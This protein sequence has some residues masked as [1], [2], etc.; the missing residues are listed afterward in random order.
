MLNLKKF[1]CGTLI[2]AATTMT[3]QAKLVLD[4]FEYQAPTDATLT[5]FVAGTTVRFDDDGE[6][7]P[8]PDTY[9]D[10]AGPITTT[11]AFGG[12]DPVSGVSGTVVGLS[13]GGGVTV[14]DFNVIGDSNNTNNEADPLLRTGDGELYV[15]AGPAYTLTISYT[16]PLGTNLQ[17][18]ASQGSAFYFDIKSADFSGANNFSVVI[19]V[20]DADGNSDTATVLVPPTNITSL[21]TLTLDFDKF[22]GVDFTRVQGIVAYIT[23]EGP[24]LDLRIS[25]VGIVPEPASIALLGLGLLCLGLRSRKK[26]A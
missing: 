15:A 6:L 21:T 8:Y 9:G 13:A 3:A 7:T 4:T 10:G 19:E 2:L 11:E 23:T 16:D 25:E 24:D 20:I 22:T 26:S 5:T 17:N 1:L 18:Y 14:Y 12:V